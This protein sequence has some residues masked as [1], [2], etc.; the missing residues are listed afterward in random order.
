LGC[1][2]PVASRKAHEG[3]AAARRAGERVRRVADTPRHAS[4]HQEASERNS[5]R[6]PEGFP[7]CK[8]QGLLPLTRAPPQVRLVVGTFANSP[9]HFRVSVKESKAMLSNLQVFRKEGR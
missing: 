1:L 6:T 7:L 3:A 8:C 9:S 5:E 4:T 2:V